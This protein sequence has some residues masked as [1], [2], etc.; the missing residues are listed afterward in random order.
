MFNVYDQQTAEASTLLEVVMSAYDQL[1][2]AFHYQE[3]SA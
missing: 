3:W 1:V 2:H